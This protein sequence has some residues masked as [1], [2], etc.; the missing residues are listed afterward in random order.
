MKHLIFTL[1]MIISFNGM[2]QTESYVG[3]YE[4]KLES[5]N[6]NLTQNL[7]LKPD[8][9]FMFH[10][11]EYHDM[12]IPKGKNVYGK[13]CWK[14]DKKIVTFSTTPRDFD[15]KHTI[16]L[17]KSKARFDSKSK[18]D[19]SNRTRKTSIRF[20]ESEILWIKGKTFIKIE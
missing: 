2:S 10:S 4:Y 16:D 15:E 11:N 3:H 20:F 14:Q 6:A 17:N 5:S 18:R 13:G 19:H 7:I 1:Y 12:G 9:S 8:G